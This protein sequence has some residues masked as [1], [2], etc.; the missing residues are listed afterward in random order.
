M[1]PKHRS[2]QACGMEYDVDPGDYPKLADL[3]TAVQEAIDEDDD[4]DDDD[5]DGDDDDDVDLGA[6][7]K[8]ELLAYIEEEDIEIE[9]ADDMKKK[10]LREAVEEA[11]EE[12][13]D[14]DSDDDDDDD[15]S[16]DDDEQELTPAKKSSKATSLI[17]TGTDL[18]EISEIDGLDSLPET[19]EIS[20]AFHFENEVKASV[21]AKALDI[22]ASEIKIGEDDTFVIEM[23]DDDGDDDDDDD[24]D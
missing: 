23:E 2:A 17:F 12:S 5:D 21:I 19:E 10:A 15:D 20:V 14:D 9:D 16:D 8:K 7:S 4:D 22:E 24:D 6:M 18:E 11:L 13:D 3:R 1:N